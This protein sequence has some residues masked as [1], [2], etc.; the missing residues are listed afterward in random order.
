[1]KRVYILV[2]AAILLCG[3]NKGNNEFDRAMLLRTDLLNANGCSFV[4]KVTADFSDRTYTF[5]MRCQSDQN[6]NVTF[7][8]LEPDYISGI[9]GKIAYDG[10]KLIFDDTALAFGLQADGLISPVSA[11]WVLVRALRGGYVRYCGQ[12]EQFLRLT[13]DDSYEEDALM[14]DIWIGADN[15]PIQAD[16]YE[17]NKRILTLVVS[18]YQ[19]L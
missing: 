18:D 13:V 14:L 8:V 17:N 6:G 3:C 11:P 9:Q 10:G 16:V 7:E 4:A 1:M 19:L 12:E 15:K 5:T 2:I